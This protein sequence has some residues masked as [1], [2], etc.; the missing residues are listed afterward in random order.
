MS[1]L[2]Y[3]GLQW[4]SHN[5]MSHFNFTKFF[6]HSFI[7]KYLICGCFRMI[8]DHCSCKLV[9]LWGQQE[10]VVPPVVLDIIYGQTVCWIG[11]FFCPLLPLLNTIKYFII[12]YLKK[13]RELFFYCKEMYNWR[14]QSEVLCQGTNNY[15]YNV[16]LYR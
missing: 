10:F 6:I 16:C 9:Q 5:V 12:F 3:L 15:I 8:V 1:S 4:K 7:F 11:T 13:V 14:K 2:A